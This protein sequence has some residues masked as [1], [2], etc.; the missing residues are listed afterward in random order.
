VA[1]AS[2][3]VVEPASFQKCPIKPALA[4][5]VF[6]SPPV[7]VQPSD[8]ILATLEAVSCP[9]VSSKYIFLSIPL[10]VSTTLWSVVDDLFEI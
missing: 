1:L 4:V 8:V 5:L 7:N 10:T 6:A 2:F 9:S 3:V